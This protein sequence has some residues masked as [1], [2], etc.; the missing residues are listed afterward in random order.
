[1]NPFILQAKPP[2]RL[3]LLFTLA[4]LV[5]SI[6]DAKRLIRVITLFSWQ[7]KKKEKKEAAHRP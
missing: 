7:Q 5:K 6:A 3:L 1:M 4:D 2:I